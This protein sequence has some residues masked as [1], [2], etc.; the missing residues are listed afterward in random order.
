[1][2][3]FGLKLVFLGVA[4]SVPARNHNTVS[5]LVENYLLDCG[6]GAVRVLQELRLIDKVDK[7]LITHAHADHFSGVVSLIW[8]FMLTG[9]NREL[10]IVGPKGIENATLIALKTFNTPLNRVKGWLEFQELDAGEKLGEIR[11][12]EARHPIPSLAY[13]LDL[14]KSLCYTGDT[15]P[16]REIVE[17]AK[18]CTLLVHDSTYPSGMEKEA[19]NDGHSTARDAGRIARESNVKMLA[20]VHLPYYRFPSEE[21]A[22]EYVQAAAQQFEGEV[23]VPKELKRYIL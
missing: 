1:M 2:G 15:S 5:L 11:A 6:E 14:D 10:L 21:F 16:S 19:L 18:N 3:D 17:L 8:Y 13:R 23:F 4:G 9:R 12:A 22:K 20:L 7:V